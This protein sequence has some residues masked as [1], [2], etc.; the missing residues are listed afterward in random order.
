MQA[1]RSTS[2]CA[3]YSCRDF[4]YERFRKLRRSSVI[5]FIA[6]CNGWTVLGYAIFGVVVFT[7]IL[8]ASAGP[9]ATDSG[10]VIATAMP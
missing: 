7:A 8:L 1:E 2:S 6:N 10:L 3:E 9:K 4:R 5:S